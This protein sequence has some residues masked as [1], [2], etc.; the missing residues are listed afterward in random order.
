MYAASKH[1]SMDHVIGALPDLRVPWFLD[2][3]CF[4]FVVWIDSGKGQL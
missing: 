3:H 2:V 1:A 4:E